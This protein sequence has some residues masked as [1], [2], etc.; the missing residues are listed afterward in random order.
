MG[1]GDAPGGGE[2]QD[3]GD[4]RDGAESG[5]EPSRDTGEPLPPSG[6]EEGGL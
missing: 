3:F 2:A 5:V 1:C 6:T 4:G